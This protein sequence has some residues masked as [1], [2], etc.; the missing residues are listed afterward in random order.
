MSFWSSQKCPSCCALMLDSSASAT[1][2][3]RSQQ[4]GLGESVSKLLSGHSQLIRSV[5]GYVEIRISHSQYLAVISV[6]LEASSVS[7]IVC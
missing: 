2:V 5:D 1:C 6:H 7:E 4:A 3:T